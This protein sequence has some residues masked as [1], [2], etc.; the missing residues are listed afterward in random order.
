MLEAACPRCRGPLDAAYDWNQITVSR[1][2]IEA[3]PSSLW[4][5]G[6][7]LPISAS[8]PHAGWTPM[9]NAPNLAARLGLNELWLKLETAHTQRDARL[10]ALAT[11]MAT[12]YGLYP[13]R[14]WLRLAPY[15]AE[16]AKT[17]AYEIAEQLGWQFP[18]C[19]VAPV[20]TGRLLI[21]LGQGFDELERVGLLTGRPPRLLGALPTG[22]MLDGMDAELAAATVAA[23]NGK[24]VVVRPP[25]GIQA[26]LEVTL[27]DVRTG[28][29]APSDTV[30]LIL[31]R[32]GPTTPQEVA[33]LID[34]ADRL[35]GDRDV[36]PRTKIRRTRGV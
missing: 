4:R 36:S 23:A 22:T 24:I 12:T 31:A 18:A 27:A 33:H 25:T 17:V 15:A 1:G 21:K 11:A 7:L 32:E 6:P 10:R 35:P 13:D 26:L 20:A 29:I 16:G 28:A 8:E 3:G 34:R 2:S 14:D 19:V 9:V 30:V 5:Y